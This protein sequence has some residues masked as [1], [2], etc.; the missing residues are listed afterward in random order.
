MLIQ[1][2]KKNLK[3]QI[4]CLFIF[5]VIRRITPSTIKI[6]LFYPAQQQS[7]PIFHKI[8]ATSYLVVKENELK[9]SEN[10]FAKELN[11]VLIKKI[12]LCQ[13]IK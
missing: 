7:L 9:I 10:K 12:M 6:T 5:N 4:N 11:S 2:E 1:L 3:I 13:K 8:M